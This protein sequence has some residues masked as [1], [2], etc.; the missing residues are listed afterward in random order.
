MD[1]FQ[2]LVFFHYLMQIY[3]LILIEIILDVT[4]YYV[5]SINQVT[6][7]SVGTMD[8]FLFIQ[9]FSFLQPK[10]DSIRLVFIRLYSLAI[11][12]ILVELIY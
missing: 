9:L 2:H 5:Q 3:Y 12:N 7:N 6:R 4:S 8:K 1:I 10:L 11:R